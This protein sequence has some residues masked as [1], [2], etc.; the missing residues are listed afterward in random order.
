MLKNLFTKPR[1]I[2]DSLFLGTALLIIIPIIILGLSLTWIF[3][4][5][6]MKQTERINTN[7]VDYVVELLGENISAIYNTAY[8][9]GN[10]NNILKHSSLKS[11]SYEY[12]NNLNK[13]VTVL[14]RQK[15]QSDMIETMYLFYLEPI[16]IVG[17]DEGKFAAEEKIQAYYGM[18]LE[19]LTE[20]FR[21]NN[22]SFVSCKV[23]N[24]DNIPDILFAKCIDAKFNE[25]GKIYAIYVLN[26]KF[27][28][29][30]IS[31][32]SLED[33]GHA[34]LLDE[35]YNLLLGDEGVY[36]KYEKHLR[37]WNEDGTD[38][39]IDSRILRKEVEK[40][41]LYL[42][43]VVDDSHYVSMI[44]SIW[45][46]IICIGIFI[47]VISVFISRFYIRRLYKPFG[48]I[49]NMFKPEEE[50]YGLKSELEFFEEK[51]IEIKNMKSE[52]ESYKHSEDSGLQEMFIHNFLKGF[53]KADYRLYIQDINISFVKAYYT[54]FTVK[55][56]NFK[57]I[58]QNIKLSHY[59]KFIK[60]KLVSILQN[61]NPKQYQELFY[62]YDGEY[63][64]LLICHDDE[65]EGIKQ[66][67][68]YLQ[69]EL[70]KMLEI[71]V[72]V[73]ISD[74]VTSPEEL[75]EE[76][77]ML[78]N[79]MLQMK[80]CKPS[81]VLTMQDYKK[82][83][84]YVNF[85]RYKKT[86]IQCISE[87][88]YDE[89]DA[90]ID[91]LFVESRVF[92]TEVIQMVTGFL[93]ITTELLEKRE[94]KVL[95]IYGKEIHPY[96]EIGRMGSVVEI[97]TYVKNLCHDVGDMLYA[98]SATKNELYDRIMDYISSNYMK[99]ISLTVMAKDFGL[100]SSYFSR[101]FKEVTGKNY[102]EMISS[103][104]VGKA[105]ELINSEDEIKMFQ[106]AEL[107]GFA[108]YKAFAEAFK[109]YSGMSP[110]S[111]KKS[112]NEQNLF[113]L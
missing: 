40:D 58:V 24:T 54:V 93:T 37:V 41:R 11:N 52:L 101:S 97:S 102:S 44:R 103:Y 66:E 67:V 34:M 72:S 53:Y 100:S 22:M 51:Y 4:S 84:K 13:I 112:L 69:R 1:K 91:K 32:I 10:D 26:G 16:E 38:K 109:K 46:T 25:A 111:Y 85:S 47:V 43:F 42:N 64:G 15:L 28:N 73:C 81:T 92:Y 68:A 90:L 98:E 19:E 87:R 36:E 63:I 110:E 77:K 107:V 96:D 12:A 3:S 20:F 80:F 31:M 56:D 9:L 48:N 104:R 106:V 95:R 7:T 8:I 89:L 49:V 86:I 5:G 50:E 79:A 30:L 27:I 23:Q 74:T 83:G 17:T 113:E 82:I 78:S 2:I 105:K 33:V 60:D 55:I 45:A 59:R 99:D 61:H 62:F 108:S 6:F 21:D 76:Y 14:S 94:G 65:I 75:V 88:K 70:L 18:S 57:A 29:S 39:S 35:E 71:T